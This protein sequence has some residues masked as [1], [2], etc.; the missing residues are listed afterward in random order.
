MCYEFENEYYLRQAEQARKAL[1]EA[2]D[3]RKQAQPAKPEDKAEQ[4]EPVPV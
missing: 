2:E 4:P 1:K 3:K